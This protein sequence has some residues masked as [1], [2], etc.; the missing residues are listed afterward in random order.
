[1]KISFLLS[2]LLSLTHWQLLAQTGAGFFENKGQWEGGF[3]YKSNIPSGNFF[4]DPTGYTLLQYNAEDV[5]KMMGHH[6]TQLDKRLEPIK[7]TPPGENGS[8]ATG[9]DISIRKHAYRV[10]FLGNTRQTRS[11]GEKPTGERANFFIGNDQSKWKTDVQS[12]SAVRVQ[13]MYPGIDVKYYTYNDKIK[14]D[15]LVEPGANP[16]LIKLK[17]E[18]A[19]KVEIIKGELV[20]TTSLGIV[21]E[22]KPY[23][24]QIIGGTKVEVPCSYQLANNQVSYKLQGYN[25]NAPLV[26]DPTILWLSTYT[27]SLTTNWGYTA[28]PGPDKSIYA[29]GIVAKNGYPVTLGN[30]FQRVNQSFPNDLWDIGITRIARNGNIPN[31]SPPEK[32]FIFSTYIGGSQEEFPHSLIVD[33]DGSVVMLGRTFSGNSFP[34]TSKWGSNGGWDIFVFK[35]SADGA[36]MIGS[37]LIGGTLDDGYN[38]ENIIPASGPTEKPY[39]LN[40]GDCSRSEVVLD[41][42]GNIF[43]AS[44]TKSSDFRLKNA[45]FTTYSGIQEGVV[46]KITPNLSDVLFSTFLGGNNFDAAIALAYDP[47]NN[48]ILVA[49]Y[50]ESTNMPGGGLRSTPYGQLDGFLSKF[51]S[52]GSHLV[53]TYFGT[54]SNDYIFAVQVDALGNPYVL[55]VSY[56]NLVNKNPTTGVIFP[57]SK[58]KQ[59]VAKLKPDL[60]DIVFTAKFGSGSGS[61]HDISPTAF[62]V[63]QCNRIFVAGWTY[64]GSCSPN[65]N[66]KLMPTVDP[67]KTAPFQTGDGKD[68]YFIVFE[69]DCSAILFASFWGQQGGGFDHVDGGTSRFDKQGVIYMA[70]CANCRGNVACDGLVDPTYRFPLVNA[71]FNNRREGDI[72]EADCNMHALIYDFGL[73]EA[74][75]A[76]TPFIN[77]VAFK[78]N[79]C[80]NVDVRF[81]GTSNGA[82]VVL[83]SPGTILPPDPG[84]TYTWEFGTV[85]NPT[86]LGTQTGKD[87]TQNFVYD[88]SIPEYQVRLTV[89]DVNKACKT[90]DVSVTTI[91]VSPIKATLDAS[92]T[93]AC[94]KKEVEFINQT[95]GD[96]SVLPP[97]GPTSFIWNI[98]GQNLSARDFSPFKYTYPAEGNYEVKLKLNDPN[99]CNDGEEFILPVFIARNVNPQLSFKSPVCIN[100]ATNQASVEFNASGGP[101]ISWK[102]FT[103]TGSIPLFT[104]NGPKTNYS[105]SAPAKYRLELRVE[106][107][108][109]CNTVGTKTE[110][111]DVGKPP[112]SQFIFSTPEENTP[113]FFTNQTSPLNPSSQTYKWDFGD[114]DSSNQINPSHLF[115]FT[116]RNDVM[117]IA[118]DNASRCSDTSMQRVF[119]RVSPLSNIPTAF[120]P[121]GVTNKTFGIIGFG[122]I[123]V[124]FQIY[125]RWGVKL[126]DTA[127]FGSLRREW[128]GTYKG[129]LQ[130]MDVYTYVAEIFYS[131]GEKE[132]KRGEVTLIR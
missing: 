55:G 30:F 54:T 126:F 24:Y 98:E 118:T 43:I 22:M 1:M 49:G 75:A 3:L 71:A 12:F 14:F 65:L 70:S 66:A 52:S 119:T 2:F 63:D 114:G 57:Q 33:N 76:I 41:N 36:N 45:S 121:L 16:S 80:S 115:N 89:V 103:E 28:A 25:K 42:A 50:T 90:T 79:G 120:T 85:S 91:K 60:S 39:R 20:I 35:L 86:L 13:N 59:F 110:Q 7:I 125:N 106:D 100:L 17:Y 122:I 132:T 31:T 5:S 46:M 51:N 6:Q 37:M 18:G 74:S 72:G 78:R 94:D 92:Y 61:E 101:N 26:I 84:V 82:T 9:D 116:K 19:D 68:F 109:A 53:S 88:P 113:V 62:L 44:N 15:I 11:K 34:H 130:P 21:K 38:H 29:A 96:P 4:I 56:G 117:L 23:A 108:L 128:D 131:D 127:E 104:A 99:Y 95:I 129:V 69:K 32:G 58:G 67:V 83:P 123:R 40:Y 105:F 73:G 97:F 8:G 124:N 48:N 107:L 111:I 102:I 87:I 27:G 10:T 112:R 47:L 93:R 64:S 77:G 81:I